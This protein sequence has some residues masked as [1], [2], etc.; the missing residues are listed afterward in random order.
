MTASASTPS[1]SGPARM[2]WRACATA[3]RPP[4]GAWWWNPPGSGEPHHRPPAHPR[5]PALSELWAGAYTQEAPTP[6]GGLRHRRPTSRPSKNTLRRS[7]SPRPAWLVKHTGLLHGRLILS[8]PE[9]RPA[10]HP[11]HHAPALSAS[12]WQQRRAGLCRPADPARPPA[13]PSGPFGTGP[14]TRNRSGPLEPGVLALGLQRHAGS[15]P[16]TRA[17]ALDRTPHR[18]RLSLRPGRQHAGVR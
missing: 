3:W 11:R 1:R 17:L 18:Q 5:Q 4:A 10:H 9:P 7:D 14:A 6:T 15:G 16:A 2:G 12:R 8:G 13:G